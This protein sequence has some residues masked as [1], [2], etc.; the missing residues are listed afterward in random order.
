MGPG[1]A[2]AAA[3]HVK[4]VSVDTILGAGSDYI[5]V[6]ASNLFYG[7]DACAYIASKV[8]SGYVLENEGDLTSSNGADRKTGFDDCMAKS[9]RTCTSCMTRLS[10]AR[11]RRLPMRRTPSM[12]TAR[13]SRRYM[14]PPAAATRG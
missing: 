8:K 12:L 10:G 13:I 14:N 3:H 2:Y 5:V 7:Y 11:P 9:T 4:V 1:L 6:R